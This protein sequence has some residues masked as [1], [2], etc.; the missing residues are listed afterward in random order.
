MVI[1]HSTD[2][3]LDKYLGINL[4]DSIDDDKFKIVFLELIRFLMLYFLFSF[5]DKTMQF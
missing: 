5:Y 1:E 3:L 4:G 2:D